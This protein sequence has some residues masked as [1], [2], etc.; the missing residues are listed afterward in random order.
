MKNPLLECDLQVL[1]APDDEQAHGLAVGIERPHPLRDLWN[2]SQ[3]SWA[4]RPNNFFLDP[5]TGDGPGL[6]C[7]QHSQKVLREPAAG[8]RVSHV[9]FKRTQQPLLQLLRAPE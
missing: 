2:L 1:Q 8:V 6:V 9:S 4:E 3:Q 5:D 7:Q